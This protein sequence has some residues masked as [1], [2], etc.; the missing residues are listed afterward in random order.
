[1]SEHF[2]QIGISVI[3]GSGGSVT[4]DNFGKAFFEN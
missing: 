3:V 1:M 4:F 2:F